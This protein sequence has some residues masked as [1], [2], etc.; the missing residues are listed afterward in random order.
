MYKLA[1]K[2]FD[3]PKKLIFG[4]KEDFNRKN[5]KISSRSEFWKQKLGFH[6]RSIKTEHDWL[7]NRIHN[8]YFQKS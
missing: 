2:P 7:K 3:S 5:V 1:E 6:H 4:R 8:C